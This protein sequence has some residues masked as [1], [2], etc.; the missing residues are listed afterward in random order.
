MF[1]VGGASPRDTSN[2][3]LLLLF[4]VFFVRRAT[5]KSSLSLFLLLP[6]VG[7]SKLRFVLL[8][9]LKGV[10][11]GGGWGVLP[12]KGLGLSGG[13]PARVLGLGG[14][15]A[16]VL[17]PAEMLGLWLGIPASE[18]KAGGGLG[19]PVAGRGARSSAGRGARSFDC[20]E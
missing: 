3:V 12:A 16:K 20:H 2:R 14:R 6:Y 1:G 15:P 13:R 5:A 19:I 10:E 9:P 18:A 7:L 8:S 4:T 17:G 11:L